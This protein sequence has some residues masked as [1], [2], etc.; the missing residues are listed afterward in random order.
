[1][2][3]PGGKIKL[4]SFIAQL[5]LLVCTAFGQ[6]KFVLMEHS[7]ISDPAIQESSGIVVSRRFEGV[8]WTHND[9]GPPLICAVD[10]DGRKLRSY[11]L[12]VRNHDWEDIALDQKGNLY[13]LDNTSRDDDRYRTLI[14]VLP[15]PA[16]FSNDK[17]TS[18]ETFAVRYDDYGHDTETLIVWKDQVILV[19]KPWDGTAPRVYLAENMRNS[20]AVLLGTL[21]K[22]AMITGG[23][24]SI[25]GKMVALSSYRALFIFEGEEPR[26]S[27][28]S[29]PLICPLNAGQIEGISWKGRDLILTNEKGSIFWVEESNWRIHDA[30][31]RPF[32]TIPVPRYDPGSL[33][34]SLPSD[35]DRGTWLDGE[36][37]DRMGRISWS[38]QGIHVAIHMPHGLEVSP[39]KEERGEDFDDW[40]LPGRIYVLV[41]PRGDRQLA[42]GSNDRCIVLGGHEGGPLSCLS[43]TLLPATYIQDS[44]RSPPWIKVERKD[45]WILVTLTS[46]GPGLELLQAGEN[47]GFNLVIIG[48]TGKILSWAPLTMDFSWDAPSFWGLIELED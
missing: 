5:T 38:E 14:H 4:F 12:P 26:E 13:L 29:D 7:K 34:R 36:E 32:P 3:A 11:E 44:K 47:I 16:P 1:L 19:S 40:F 27:L 9:D 45:R 10:L 15:E 17:V 43:R 33:D 35:W 39:L 8:F 18:V 46:E 6:D 22:R 2:I 30:P 48:E 21:P 28:L 25:D 41:N 31:R 37:L 42:F 20:V 23:D 24:H